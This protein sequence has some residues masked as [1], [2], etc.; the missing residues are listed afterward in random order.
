MVHNRKLCV[1]GGLAAAAGHYVPSLIVI[2]TVFSLS[3]WAIHSKELEWKLACADEGLLLDCGGNRVI[4]I[5]EASF[6]SDVTHVENV[7]CSAYENDESQLKING[8]CEEDIRI[9]IN[10]RCSGLSS[11]HFSYSNYTGRKCDSATGVVTIQYDCVKESTINKYCNVRIRSKE[12]Y[13]SSP[14]YPQFYPELSKCEWEIQAG[15]GQTAI[16]RLLDIHMQ[17]PSQRYGRHFCD[18]AITI[19]EGTTRRMMVCG[20]ETESLQTL[21]ADVDNGLV[22]QFTSRGFFPASGFL[23]YF[24]VQGCAT[25]PAPEDGY[26]VHRNGSSATYICCQN[27]FFNDTQENSRTLQCIGEHHWNDTLAPCI[28]MSELKQMSV[29]HSLEFDSEENATALLA[30]PKPSV[31]SSKA[32]Y[33]EDILVPSILMAALLLG[34][35]LIVAIILRIRRKQKSKLELE[36]EDFSPQRSSPEATNV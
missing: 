33:M 32:S 7:S 10:R 2:L 35:A 12:G 23:I 24:K 5:H 9:P 14:G 3:S 19:L 13:I 27:Y 11:C 15:D 31:L 16:F 30:E 36:E 26:L 21:E 18:D 6:S 1:E 28:A 4:A 17:T 20:S 29:N 22:V 25:L 34:N 8:S